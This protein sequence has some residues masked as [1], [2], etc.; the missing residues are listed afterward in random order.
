[1]VCRRPEG[2]TVSIASGNGQLCG[3]IRAERTTWKT[4]CERDDLAL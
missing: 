3:E 2:A 1:M 4:E